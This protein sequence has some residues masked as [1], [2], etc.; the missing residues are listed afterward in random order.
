M[1]PSL[2]QSILGIASGALVGLSLGLV[3]DGGSILAVPLLVEGAT[4]GVEAVDLDRVS[5]R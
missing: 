3:G 2:I 1:A 4:A 5:G